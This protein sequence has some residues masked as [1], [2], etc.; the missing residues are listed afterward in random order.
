[1]S[2]LSTQM[3]LRD[4]EMVPRFL[5]QAMFVLMGAS[6]ALVAYARLTERPLVG[7]CPLAR[8]WPSAH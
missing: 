6:L 1:M 3:K 7:T 8:S 2:G 4:R 5:V